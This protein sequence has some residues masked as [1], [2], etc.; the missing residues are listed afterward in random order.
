[1][2]CRS[3]LTIDRRMNLNILLREHDIDILCL[4]ETWLTDEVRN[5]E[6]FLNRQ[7]FVQSRKDRKVGTHGGTLIVHKTNLCFNKAAEIETNFDFLSCSVYFL[8]NI[9]LIII[10]LYNPPQNN[11]YRVSDTD[12][13][14]SI[15]IALFKLESLFDSSNQKKLI[16]MN[17]DIN[18]SHADWKTLSS[19]NEYENAFIKEID[20]L[21]L[22]SIL[23]SSC[24]PDIFL[25]NNLEQCNLVV[26]ANS[27]SDHKL[28]IAEISV[29]LTRKKQKPLFQNL[30][31]NKADWHL[32]ISH[33]EIPTMSNRCPNDLLPC[34]YQSFYNA[35]EK[36]IPRITKRRLDAPSYMSSHSVHIENKLK[37]L[38]KTNKR[39]EEIRN[40]EME[41]NLFLPKDKQNFFEGFCIS[42]NNDAYKFLRRLNQ[43]QTFPEKM[44][45]RGQDIMGSLQKAESFNE[46]FSSVFIEDNSDIVVPET[47]QPEIFLD[48]ITFNAKSVLDEISQTKCGANSYD[49]ITP[50]LLKASAPYVINSILYIFSC[51]INAC[52][53]PK[54]WKNTHV[55]PHH[56]NDSKMEIKNYI[57]IAMLCAISIVFERIVYKQIKKTFE[58]KLCTAQHGFRQKHST[59]TQPN[60]YYIVITFIKL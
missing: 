40:L 56:K 3:I 34:F 6:I 17:G 8:N 43:E 49:Q 39:A 32:F 9:V 14:S 57:P 45:Y 42:T 58:R 10:T 46:H 28:F 36:S 19:S 11:K 20:A 7:Y 12:L 30:N 52:Q 27:F 22:C 60:C 21:N 48:D 33:F 16:I 4:T 54:V 35:C 44:K 15:S 55:R 51:I 24:C 25:C 31:I 59:V 26:E 38:R 37:T 50:S 29:R 1:M 18:F 47:A 53:F 5:S 13:R 2:N 41:L 23:N